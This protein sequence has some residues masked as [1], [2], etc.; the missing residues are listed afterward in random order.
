MW[1]A[2]IINNLKLNK[3]TAVDLETEMLDEDVAE[4][5]CKTKHAVMHCLS[6]LSPWVCVFMGDATGIYRS[7]IFYFSHFCSTS[8]ATRTI[9]IMRAI[10][11]MLDQV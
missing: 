6:R 1:K 5:V 4:E 9:V 10:L 11:A 8:G 2:D 3:W 7:Y